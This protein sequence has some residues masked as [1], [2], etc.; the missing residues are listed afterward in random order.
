MQSSLHSKEI[1]TAQVAAVTFGFFNDEEVRK[2]SV[3]QVEAPMIFDNMRTAVKGG[4]Y[5]PALGPM[6]PKERCATCGLSSFECPGHFGH[7]QLAVP[8]YNPLVF[9]LVVG[10]SAAA[11]KAGGEILDEALQQF[12]DLDTGAA[13][14]FSYDVAKGVKA[15]AARAGRG[16]GPRS[17]VCMTAQTL[18]AMIDTIGDFFRKQPTGGKCHNCGANNPTIRR[19][20]HSKL[21]MLPLSPKRRAQNQVQGTPI[22]S[23]LARLAQEAKEVENLEAE[24]ALGVARADA[25]RKRRRR[26][27]G[28]V[29][30][31]GGGEEEE[32]EVEEEEKEDGEKDSLM[33]DDDKDG[34]SKEGAEGMD[35][36]GGEDRQG[37]QLP[38][39]K[40]QRTAVLQ[41]AMEAGLSGGHPTYLTPSEVKEVLRRMWELNEPILAYIYPTE[42]TAQ[43]QL[44]KSLRLWLDLQNSLNALIDSNAAENTHGVGGIKQLLEKKEGLFRKNMMGKRVNFAARSGALCTLGAL[45]GTHALAAP[46]AHHLCPP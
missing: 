18:E 24:L 5:D 28:G 43:E 6:D 4:L 42:S 29:K 22:L 3:K 8:L 45:C 10:T 17:P 31:E 36:D 37:R 26:A 30:G 14:Q 46:S 16:M 19:E 44:G 27:G 23:V 35:V 11:K 21:F 2:I 9:I 32:E 34:E 20:G 1:T 13:K 39:S 7:I 38:A 41:H 33:G 15:S 40:A 25:S 12:E